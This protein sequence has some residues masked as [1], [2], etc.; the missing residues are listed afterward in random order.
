MPQETLEKTAEDLLGALAPLLK[1][2]FYLAGGTGLALQFNHRQSQDLD[3]FSE[4]KISIAAL[5]TN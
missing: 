1:P 5:K 4:Q 3:F 2:Q